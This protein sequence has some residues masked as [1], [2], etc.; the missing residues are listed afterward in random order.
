LNQ[1]ASELTAI[2]DEYPPEVMTVIYCDTKIAGVQEFH[3]EDLPLKLEAKGGG[4]TNFQPPF[5]WVEEQGIEPVCFIY[6]TDMECNRFPEEYPE[7]P[8]MWVATQEPPSYYGTPPFG[9]VIEM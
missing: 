5:E 6:L 4:G 1:F 9:E 3:K 2:L 7:Y 8:V